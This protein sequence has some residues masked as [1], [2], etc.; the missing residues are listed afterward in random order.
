MRF[1][2]KAVDGYGEK[3]WAALKQICE[4][5]NT[6]SKY[7]SGFDYDVLLTH[8]Y[9]KGVDSDEWHSVFGRFM[10]ADTPV[11]EGF[12]GLDFMPEPGDKAG[13]PYISQ[14]AFAT[15]VGDVNAMHKHEGFDGDG[16]YDVTRNIILG[17]GVGIPY[18]DKYW[19]A[20][21]WLDGCDKEST[22][23]MFSVVL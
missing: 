13:T 4:T 10:I 2:G 22:A 14:F 7:A 3:D 18:P 17:Q 16:M 8:L 1:I 20:E 9:G 6:I 5:M 21:V 23:Y 11:P 19:T 15:F 12:I